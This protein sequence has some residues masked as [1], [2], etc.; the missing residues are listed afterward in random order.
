MKD[1]T[2]KEGARKQENTKK[3]VASTPCESCEFYDADEYGDYSCIMNLD[4]DEFLSFA[5]GSTSAC[6]YYR[7]YDEY[8]F[9]QKQN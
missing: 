5:F 1:G 4:E 3:A 7:F 8:K 6:P 2:K 9:V